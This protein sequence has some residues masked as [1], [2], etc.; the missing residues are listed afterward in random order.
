MK[1]MIRRKA[2]FWMIC[3]LLFFL[4]PCHTKAKISKSQKEDYTSRLSILV[5][6]GATS[7]NM[8]EYRGIYNTKTGRDCLKKAV[9]DNRAALIAEK[10]DALDTDWKNYYRVTEQNDHIMFTSRKMVSRS[11]YKKRYK[12]VRKGLNRIL[13]QVE[14]SMTEADKAMEIY[15]YL[16]KNTLY[17]NTSDSHTGYDVL[18]KNTGV[19]DG[20][21]NVYAMA[22]NALDIP[23]IVVSNYRKDH[24]WNMV[25]ISG[26][27]YFCDLTLGVGP[28]SDRGLVMRYDSCLVGM[29]TFLNTHYGYSKKDMYGQ[30]NSDGLKI[31]KLSISK[32]DYMG[33]SMKNGLREK[34]C[35]FYNNGYWYWISTSNELY[36]SRLNGSG[37]TLVYHPEENNY[38]GWIDSHNGKIILSINDRINRYDEKSKTLSMIYRVP[39]TEYHSGQNPYLWQIGSINRFVIGNDGK[40]S[41]YITDYKTTK[42]GRKKISLGRFNQSVLNPQLSQKNMTLVQ[43]RERYIYLFGTKNVSGSRILWTS[44]N[45]NIVKVDKY[46]KI[47]AIKPGRATVYAKWKGRKRA[48]KIYVKR[49]KKK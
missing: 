46:G 44:S 41:Y 19:C 43:G 32:S 9:L 37:K 31:S 20:M 29:D 24:S 23:C 3:F 21:S 2:C 28:G 42:A 36:R 4:V 17:Q 8:D 15:A 27:W 26:K 47:K 5:R 14:K 11:G 16:S 7:A 22:L 6:S 33:K 25:K 18:T 1:K 35:T 40:M 45:K 38:I 48:C 39:Q 49:T 30:G 12:L 13:G 34:T 10:I